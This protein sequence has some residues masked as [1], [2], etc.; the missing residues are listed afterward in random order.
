MKPPVIYPDLRP[1]LFGP[2]QTE[3]GARGALGMEQ[4]AV[5]G[6]GDRGVGNHDLARREGARVLLLPFRSR[7]EEGDLEAERL[8]GSFQPAG[9][10]PPFEPELRMASFVVR[11]AHFVA[12]HHFREGGD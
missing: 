5:S 4:S 6:V 7:P 9:D 8:A 10:V 3:A 2:R 12:R 1:S 11:E